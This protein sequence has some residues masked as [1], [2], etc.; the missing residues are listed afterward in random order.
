M[1]IPYFCFLLNWKLESILFHQK[2]DTFIFVA[3]ARIAAELYPLGC[4][5]SSSLAVMKEL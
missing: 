2:I 3:M 1:I 4:F 5:P